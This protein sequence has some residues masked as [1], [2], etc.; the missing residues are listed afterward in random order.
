MHK[1]LLATLLLAALHHGRAVAAEGD[2]PGVAV[3]FTGPGGG[4]DVRHQDR[5]AL[6]V[7]ADSPATPFLAPGPFTATF[8]GKLV[9]EARSRLYFSCEGRGEVTLL[10]GGETALEGFGAESERL[11]LNSGEHDL[12]L[13]YRAPAE[14]D[15]Q[16]RLFWRGREFARETLPQGALVRPASPALA[17]AAE[18]RRGRRLL[19]RRRCA[20][21]HRPE[22]EFGPDAM[23][24]LSRSAPAWT[25]MTAMLSP[26]WVAGWLR[27]PGPGCLPPEPG[28]DGSDIAVL[29]GGAG[30]E[31]KLGQ[32]D[33]GRTLV[34]ERHLG[35]WASNEWATVKE[36]FAQP[37]WAARWLARPEDYNPGTGLPNLGL[38]DKDLGDLVAYLWSLTPDASRPPLIG[39]REAGAAALARD[40][41]L[42]CH[43]DKA[44][45]AP[46]LESVF[47]I[48]WEQRFCPK[49]LAAG[50]HRV[51]DGAEE[52]TI[53]WRTE[54]A[55]LARLRGHAAGLDS[56]ARRSLPE[57]AARMVKEIQCD[58]CHN[59]ATDLPNIDWAGEKFQPQWLRRLFAG[60]VG[61]KPRGWLKAHMPAFPARAEVLA[62]GLA[63]AHGIDPGEVEPALEADHAVGKRLVFEEGYACVACHGVGDRPPTAV[64]EGQGPWLQHS[65]DRLR[66][67]FYLR[68]ARDPQ[69]LAPASIMPRYVGEDGVA[70]LTDVYEGDP[71]K[72]FGAIWS[73][74]R[75][76]PVE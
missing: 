74:L 58:R 55:A 34:A 20:D 43:G 4:T 54:R 29:F 31:F 67:E 73:W 5:V 71:D 11:R 16:L 13:R 12:E 76:L 17:A 9:L 33:A 50:R 65:R 61:Y 25:N 26:H 27:R 3:E 75:T 28:G 7:E 38:S 36:R 19:A 22:R 24:E 6:H 48:D 18:V 8:R 2:Q 30:P 15:A 35:A 66:H 1:A 63:Q 53:A 14:G 72:Q 51:A 64:F 23:P 70:N 42:V 41:C 44:P 49:P 52:T 69:R 59:A 21:C 32:A 47:S 46:S 68:W 60:E 62:A 45:D 10:I 40:S 39:D 57:A 56:L 37:G